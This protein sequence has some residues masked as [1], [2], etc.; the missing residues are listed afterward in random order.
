MYSRK[1]VQPRMDQK[2][3]IGCSPFFYYKPEHYNAGDIYVGL[4]ILVLIIYLK[5]N[6]TT[7]LTNED[8]LSQRI[9]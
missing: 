1:S 9:F 5:H 4:N 7:G 2:W 8:V 6:I 3:K